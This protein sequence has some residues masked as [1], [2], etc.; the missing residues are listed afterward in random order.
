MVTQLPN[1]E[2]ERGPLDAFIF[3]WTRFAMQK[4][5]HPRAST[6]ALERGA[7]LLE[8]L[9]DPVELAADPV[10]ELIGRTEAQERAEL[11]ADLR[12]QAIGLAMHTLADPAT[13][14][15]DTIAELD[16]A[17]GRAALDRLVATLDGDMQ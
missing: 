15:D 3:T 14:E 6:Q 4:Q 9:R 11:S 8:P 5:L 7:T 2:P 12:V 10:E 16:L 1:W 17:R 13:G